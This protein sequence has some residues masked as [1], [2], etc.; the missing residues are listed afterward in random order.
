[1][2]LKLVVMRPLKHKHIHTYTVKSVYDWVMNVSLT[3]NKVLQFYV[4]IYMSLS[5][6]TL[7]NDTLTKAKTSQERSDNFSWMYLNNT[8]QQ[9]PVTFYVLCVVFHIWQFNLM[10]RLCHLGLC[11]VFITKISQTMSMSLHSKWHHLPNDTN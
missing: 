1:M 10:L 4:F 6:I 9:Q 3:S 7:S 2:V 8:K 11:Q 5:V